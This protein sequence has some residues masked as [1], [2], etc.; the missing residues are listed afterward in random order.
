MKSYAWVLEVRPGYEEEY[1]KRHDEIWPEMSEEIT[2]S[3]ITNYQIFRH[4]LT[5]FG[6]FE[7]EDLQ[8]TIDYLSD[9]E[10]NAK[11]GTYMTPIMKIEVDS[12]TGF[13]FLLPNQF[14][15]KA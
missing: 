7:T 4:G 9:S 12:Q 2:K 10:V 13:P 1:K 14:S 8:K 6:Y 15:F 3:G 5:L 11:W